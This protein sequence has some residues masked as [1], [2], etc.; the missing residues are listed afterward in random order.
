VLRLKDVAKVELGI[1]SYTYNNMV[2]S[3]NGTTAM[4]AQTAGSNAHDINEKID[5]LVEEMKQD[6]PE[7]LEFSSL[8]DT[9]DFLNAAISDV[10]RTLLET[11]LLVII[12]MY[13]FL[14]SVR[15]TII[16]CVVML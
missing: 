8:M 4:V 15:S 10:V 16:F 3:H 13:V 11:I 2:N 6:L 12:V 9:N 5:K 1:Q 14:Q 7:G